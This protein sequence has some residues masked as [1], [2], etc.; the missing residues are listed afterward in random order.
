MIIRFQIDRV[1]NPI[2]KV[3]TVPGD[4]GKN[5]E[6]AL[7][8]G[9]LRIKKIECMINLP[10]NCFITL[11]PRAVEATTQTVDLIVDLTP[12]LLQRF[13]QGRIDAAKLLLQRVEFFIKRLRCMFES[14]SGVFA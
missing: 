1:E 14:I 3:A 7:L 9:L 10:M 6:V 12:S 13:R 11:H 2:D 4:K 8:Q 5:I